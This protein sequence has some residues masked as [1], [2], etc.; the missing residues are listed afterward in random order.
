MRLWR[1][2]LGAQDGERVCRAATAATAATS[3]PGE[4]EGLL[5]RDAHAPGVRPGGAG[6][7]HGP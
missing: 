6:A 7:A 1:L 2:H 4:A 5:P 3:P